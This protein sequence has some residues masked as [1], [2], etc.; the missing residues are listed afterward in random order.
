MVIAS[1]P[2]LMRAATSTALSE[3]PPS[4]KKLA[5][6]HGRQA[7]AHRQNIH[8]AVAPSGENATAL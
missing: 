8:A 2:A 6:R 4:S 7:A 5:E 3:L 1:G